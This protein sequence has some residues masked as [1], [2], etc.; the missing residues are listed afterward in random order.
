[1]TYIALGA[2]SFFL[3]CLFG[4]ISLK[5]VPR[6]KIYIW[7]LS[8]GLLVFSAIALCLSPDKLPLPA[9]TRWLGWGLF[10]LSLSLLVYALF[11]N[12]P[13]ARTYVATDAERKLITTGLYALVRHPGLLCL[14]LTL[15]S[16]ILVSHSRL[17][18]TATPLWLTLDA[19]LVLIDDR[20]LFRRMFPGYANYQKTT[21][22]LLP[23]KRSIRAFL[24]SINR[25]RKIKNI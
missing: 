8:N 5:K 18:L 7:L 16:L 21:P 17:L 3:M 11:I 4:F 9:W 14:A 15:T 2:A 19:L 23:N 20:Y 22:M 6:I 12:L 1:M 24:S 10:S 13:F 25:D